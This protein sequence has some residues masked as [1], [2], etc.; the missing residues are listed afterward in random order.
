MSSAHD[1]MERLAA[2][3][4]IRDT[5]LSP[6]DRRE[7]D[8]LLERL[9]AT[10]AQ[11]R[12]PRPNPRRRRPLLAAATAGAAVAVFAALSLLD[13]DESPA[14]NVVAKAVAALTQPDAVYHAEVIG[15]MRSS[16][17]SER[18]PSV[19]FETW[20][21]TAGRMHQRTYAVKDRH[22][23]RL[24][25]DFAGQRRP[26]RLG[27]PALIWDAHSNTI[28]ESGF[29][30]DLNVK[31]APSVDP[32]NPGEGLRE[33]QAEGRLRLAGE[34]EIDGK[35]AYRLVSGAV[36]GSGHTVQRSEILV[37]AESYLPREQRLLVR[38]PDGSTARLVWRYLTYERLPLNDETSSLL[39]FDPP[40][41]AKCAPA[42]GHLTRKGSLGFPNPCAR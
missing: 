36:R 4:P 26:G 7:A 40:P 22:R 24:L 31:G 16:D 37:D 28:N 18:N 35:P 21:T 23:G 12:T 17:V 3:D 20:H 27:G 13:A 14:P 29:G 30:R 34:V 5:A 41:G 38:S 33:L 6:E 8:A 32:F 10:P 19:F 25:G 2:A 11:A 42:A 1:P 9:L 39:D 15:H